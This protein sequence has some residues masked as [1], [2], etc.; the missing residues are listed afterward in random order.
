VV[1]GWVTPWEVLVLHSFLR[2]ATKHA[3][4]PSEVKRSWARAVLG[5]VTPW[6]ALV[7]RSFLP[8]ATKSMRSPQR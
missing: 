8:R 1:L 4:L 5:W 7:L 2:R 6:E 3:T